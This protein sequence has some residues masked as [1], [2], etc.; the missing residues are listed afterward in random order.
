MRKCGP[1]ILTLLF[2]GLLGVSA[3]ISPDCSGAIPICTNTPVNGGAY[4]YGDDDFN[5]DTKSG[6]LEQS[7][8]AGTIE[9]NSGWYRFTTMAS[10]QL[11]FNIGF[12]SSE[13]WDFALYRTNDCSNLG[14]PIRCN[15][16]DN[17]ESSSFI[18]VGEDPT[19]MA[20]SIQYEDWLDVNAGENYY[21]LVNNYS[22]NN[23]G[24]SIQFSGSIFETNPYDALDCS[25]ISN[26]LGP[27]VAACENDTVALD[28]TTPNATL[29]N[30][31]MDTGIGYQQIVG[32]NSPM[33]NVTA[34]AMYRVEVV[35]PTG[36]IYSDVQ[37]AFSMAPITFMVT[38]EA[39][40]LVEG[41]SFDLSQ[42]NNEALGSQSP[43][44]FIVSYHSSLSDAMNGFNKLPEQYTTT[45]G[46]ET[47][48]VRISSLANPK[49]FDASRQFEFASVE[50]PIADFPLE[51]FLCDDIVST[52]IGDDTPSAGYTYF[53]STG[54]IT[55]TID[56]YEAGTYD[57][58]I[59]NEQFGRACSETF[60]ITV[61][62]SKAP[63]I[64]DVLIDD[65]Q[66]Y[67]NVTI[68]T[69][70]EG[71]FEYSL[72]DGEYQSSGN[73]EDVL[74]GE[75]IV[76][77][78]DLNGCGSV[79]ESIMVVGFPKYFSPNGDGVNDRWEIVG[80]TELQDPIVF[81][82]DKFGKLLGQ[83][84]ENNMEWDGTYNGK[85]LPSTD[86]WFKLTYIDSEGQRVEAKYVE[87]HFSLRR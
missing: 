15:F 7:T 83:I 18:G 27:P 17:S 20:N 48:Y 10:G 45:V 5:G 77:I 68:L 62:I 38:D 53:W 9:S 42:K 58:T 21:L 39:Y 84:D 4:D 70:V 47:I 76:T 35:T 72:D 60:S 37:V 69:D 74:P 12:D 26:L 49:C 79:S 59:T 13:D 36:N 67:N 31:F 51:V 71:D 34:S 87:N 55:P 41:D 40:C 73:F 6:C 78:N 52:S 85:Q 29:Y 54:A 33:I 61:Y 57:L 23:S 14:D 63:V 25:I 8:M 86:Y 2:I 44:E 75:H 81:V 32:E 50:M 22:N 80:M 82:F 3:Q 56:V 46:T 43:S 24:F 65:L 30:W 11:G 64:T 28:A 1:L 66:Q 16:F 19:G